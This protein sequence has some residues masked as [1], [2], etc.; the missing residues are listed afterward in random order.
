MAE[1]IKSAFAGRILMTLATLV[2]GVVPPFVDLGDTHVFHPDWTPHSR[3]H[4]VWLLATMS[5]IAVLVL[6]LIWLH[7]DQAFGIWMAG[8]LGICVLGGFYVS[9]ATMSL[10]GGALADKG[11]IAPVMSA[12]DANLLGFSVTTALL[13]AGWFLARTRRA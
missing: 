10:Y 5:A 6:Y 2:Y 12:I 4:M 7:A 11:G 3:M 1:T 13:L 9:A 8:I